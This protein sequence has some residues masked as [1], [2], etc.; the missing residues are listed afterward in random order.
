MLKKASSGVLAR[1]HHATYL[2]TVR[3]GC[4]LAAAWL[5]DLFEHPEIRAYVATQWRL[6][7]TAGRWHTS[8]TAL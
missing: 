6:A 3:L 2:E 4:S 7:R 1:F 8:P 5:E